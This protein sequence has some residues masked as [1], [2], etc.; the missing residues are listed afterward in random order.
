MND[1]PW[2]LL[3][4]PLQTSPNFSFACVGPTC[5]WFNPRY[6]RCAVFVIALGLAS[7]AIDYEAHSQN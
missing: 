7:L 3:K 1:E 2:T 5:A 6:E 4:C